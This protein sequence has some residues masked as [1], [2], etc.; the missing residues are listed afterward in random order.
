MFP[1]QVFDKGIYT[2]TAPTGSGKTLAMMGFALNHAK[3]NKL[4]RIIIVLP[5]CNI[6]DQTAKTYKNIFDG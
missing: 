5:F 3:V 2:L 1:M 6:I 4:R